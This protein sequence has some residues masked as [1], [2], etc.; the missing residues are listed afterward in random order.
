MKIIEIN[1]K[2]EAKKK[3][4]IEPFMFDLKGR[5]YAFINLKEKIGEDDKNNLLPT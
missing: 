3:K 2:L 5:K 4:R 1:I